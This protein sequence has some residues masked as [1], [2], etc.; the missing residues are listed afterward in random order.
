MILVQS[1]TGQRWVHHAGFVIGS[2][3]QA[4]VAHPGCAALLGAGVV[5][6]PEDGTWW[7]APIS[8]PLWW[9]HGFADCPWE[10]VHTPRQLRQG[11]LL[12]CGTARFTV[13]P[14]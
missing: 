7:A 10:R 2:H 1:S 8:A 5:L 12:R 13:V 3:P 4:G 14:G 11:D 6:R 9:R